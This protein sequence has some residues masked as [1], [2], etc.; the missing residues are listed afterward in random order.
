MPL[1]FP[2][3]EVESVRYRA[4]TAK[5]AGFKPQDKR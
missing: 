5:G 4:V 1:S 3:S 2:Q